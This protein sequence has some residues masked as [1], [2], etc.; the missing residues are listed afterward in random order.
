MDFSDHSRGRPEKNIKDTIRN[1]ELE[2]KRYTKAL[3]EQKSYIEVLEKRIKDK[4]KLY[5][6][7]VSENKVLLVFP[8]PQG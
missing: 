3:M 2:I 8:A 5:L 7:V 1:F 4:D 6:D